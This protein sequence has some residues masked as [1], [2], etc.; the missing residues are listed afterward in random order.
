MSERLIAQLKQIVQAAGGEFCGI[1]TAITAGDDL[2]LFNSPTTGSTLAVKFNPINFDDNP[3]ALVTAIRK[4]LLESD[5]DFADRK[6]H[7]KASVLESIHDT[8]IAIASELQ[9]LYT[10]KE[11]S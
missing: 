2:L 4:R 5:K 9:E 3:T 11:K 7:V 10:K 8:L 1:Q 6:I